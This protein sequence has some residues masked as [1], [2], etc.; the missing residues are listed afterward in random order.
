M[1]SLRAKVVGVL[2]D[3]GGLNKPS[4]E[5]YEKAIYAFCERQSK[6]K[7]TVDGYRRLAYDKLG[8]LIEAN[9]REEREQI[10]K[11]IRNNVEGWDACVY[12]KQLEAYT[13]S[14]DRS[15]MKPKAV[16]GLHK[17]KEKNC[18]SDEFYIWSAQT[19]S[20]DEG[21]THFRQCAKC[22]KRGKE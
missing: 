13:M 3:A 8:Q 6:G 22:G 17:C 2:V 7:V 12:S 10:L 20:S 1:K 21:M 16:K 4:A 18:G 19:R 9:N 15:V 5:N 11:D 14:M